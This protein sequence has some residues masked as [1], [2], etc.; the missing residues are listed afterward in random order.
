MRPRARQ[1]ENAMVS[2]PTRVVIGLGN[3]LRGDDGVVPVLFEDL[4]STNLDASVTLLEFQDVNL[5]LFHALE[6]FDQVLLVDA[7][8]FGGDPGD[9]VLFSPEQARTVGVQGGSHDLN[10]LKLVDLADRLDED[11]ATI[12]I[13]GIQPATMEPGTGLSERLGSRFPE[14][15][16]SLRNAI[17]DLAEI[18]E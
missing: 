7:V 1:S 5:R 14:L 16:T 11:T 15:K 9:H 17:N 3:P 13:F 12:R 18:G 10:P 8:N 2:C 4:R 6:E